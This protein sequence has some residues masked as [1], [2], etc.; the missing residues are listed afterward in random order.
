MDIHFN[1]FISYRHHPDDIRVAMQVHR[2]LERYHIPRS[3][4]K[5][6]NVRGPMRLFRDKEEL[7]ITSNLNDD[8]GDALRNS[9]YLIV[10]CSV[11][12]KESIWVQREIELFLK[13]HPRHRVLTVLASGEP[14]DVIPEILLYDDKVD[15]VTGETVRELVEP[16]SCD[17]RIGPRRAKREELP[18]L[19]APLLGCA[20]D[21]LRQRQR[22]YRMRRLVAFFSLA[23]AASVGFSAYVL[24]N[25]M[26]I[27]RKNVEIQANLEASQRNQS[28]HLATAAW[29]R[30]AEG[31]RLTAICLAAAAL[32]GEN[33]VRPY[34]AEAENALTEALGIYQQNIETVAVGTVSPGSQVTVTDFYVSPSGNLLYLRDDR[35]CITVWDAQT[36]ERVGVWDFSQGLPSDMFFLP[37]DTA[38][39]RL[40]TDDGTVLRCMSPEGVILWEQPDCYDVAIVDDGAKL[41]ILTP[42]SPTQDGLLYLDPDTGEQVGERIPVELTTSLTASVS[43]YIQ[44]FPDGFPIPLRYGD[45]F[46][47]SVYL[48]HT[49]DGSLQVLGK[50][51]FQG[52]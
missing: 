28:R 36:L 38:L 5:K 3:L 12:T 8:I 16:L 39:V 19:A 44:E 26:I 15:P 35:R 27:Q 31:D 33:N 30:L 7:P 25:S 17:W 34:V 46:D 1:A 24:R 4:K 22:Q 18:R 47:Q 14:Y 51:N 11:H 41:L 40:N 2:A 13:S 9:D 37:N 50:R 10:I 6:L 49:E 42:I 45:F 52:K 32:P 48:M 21:E 23:L 29:E 20:Y 43:F